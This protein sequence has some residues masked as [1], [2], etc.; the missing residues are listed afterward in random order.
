VALGGSVTVLNPLAPINYLSGYYYGQIPFVS[1][2]TATF[3]Q[4]RLYFIPMWINISKAFDL[5][6]LN[7]TVLQASTTMRLGIFKSDGTNNLPKTLQ[8]DAGTI[9]SST[10]GMKTISIS[11]TLT[12]G[13]WY[14]GAVW[15]GG[16][17]SP[18]V[19]SNSPSY[20]LNMPFM[21]NST[22][23]GNT[24]YTGYYTDSVTG[25]FASTYTITGQ[26]P[27]TPQVVLRAV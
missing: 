20:S 24:A 7:V 27:S 16:S 9:D 21:G 26:N 2:S 12:P 1:Q 3:T 19:N 11:Q 10:T 25:A 15:Q 18:T 22:G 5:I 23:T 6:G 13:L 8:L 14:L 17:V 4:N